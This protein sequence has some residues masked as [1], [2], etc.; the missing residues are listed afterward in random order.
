M[1]LRAIASAEPSLHNVVGNRGPD[2]TARESELAETAI[3][4]EH[5][6]PDGT[7]RGCAIEGA[8][9]VVLTHLL[10]SVPP[11]RLMDRRSHRDGWAFR[12]ALVNGRSA[13]ALGTNSRR[14]VI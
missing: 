12:K 9:H 5:E 10:T 8:A 3:P 1:V 2:L 6:G 11:D 14:V 13:A 7:P 4:L